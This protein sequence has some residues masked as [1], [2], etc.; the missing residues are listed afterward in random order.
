MADVKLVTRQELGDALR[1]T[2]QSISKAVGNRKLRDTKFNGRTGINLYDP[3]TQSYALK[4]CQRENLPLPPWVKKKESE[5]SIFMEAV[6]YAYSRVACGE[7]QALST[8]F[9]S[10]IIAYVKEKQKEKK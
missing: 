3:M 9:K 8:E 5:I 6:D 4:R 2:K 1:L 10:E 7:C